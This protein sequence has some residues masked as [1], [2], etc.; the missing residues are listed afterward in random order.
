[1]GVVSKTMQKSS[2]SLFCIKHNPTPGL[3][4]NW[5]MKLF[6]K[7]VDFVA[8]SIGLYHGST[9][10]MGTVARSNYLDYHTTTFWSFTLFA[11]WVEPLI[12]CVDDLLLGYCLET[13]NFFPIRIEVATA[14]LYDFGP[15]AT[16]LF[17]KRLETFELVHCESHEM[18][19]ESLFIHRL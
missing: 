3:M 11:Q 14:Q 9:Q 15:M 8:C 7:T 17:F 13:L 1:M 5:M 16:C 18:P 19:H 4:F 12:K 2:R 10:R 6:N